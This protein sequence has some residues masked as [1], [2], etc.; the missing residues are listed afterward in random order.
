MKAVWITVALLGLWADAAAAPI[1]PE[2]RPEHGMFDIGPDGLDHIA[3]D[4]DL[5]LFMIEEPFFGRKPGESRAGMLEPILGQGFPDSDIVATTLSR[6]TDLPAPEPP[7]GVIAVAGLAFLGICEMLRR[8]LRHG[9][10]QKK[11]PGR[12]RVRIYLR[13]M[14]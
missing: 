3:T 12:R 14:S 10:K 9:E 13:K 1:G 6:G 7:T 4:L 8:T 2:W 5:P 11:T